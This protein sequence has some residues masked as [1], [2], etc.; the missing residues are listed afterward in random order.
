MSFSDL[1]TALE[2]NRGKI[3]RGICRLLSIYLTEACLILPFVHITH[4]H[5]PSNCSYL[6]SGNVY[7]RGEREQG[8]TEFLN[9]ST[10]LNTIWVWNDADHRRLS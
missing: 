10:V 5:N 1:A 6:I 4:L 7:V 3:A 9:E 2:P 8:G